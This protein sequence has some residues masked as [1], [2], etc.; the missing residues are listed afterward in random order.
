MNR[1]WRLLVCLVL[2]LSMAGCSRADVDSSTPAHVGSY[3]KPGNTVDYT[4]LNADGTFTYFERGR[5]VSGSYTV[6]GDAITLVLA[7]GATKRGR[8]ERD[9]II[10]DEGIAWVRV[11]DQ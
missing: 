3:Q 2:L 9:Q 11:D 8:I 10:D 7:N 5:T 1:V 4:D 6:E